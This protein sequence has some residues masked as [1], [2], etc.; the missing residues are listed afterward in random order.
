MCGVV[1]K[2]D[3][4]KMTVEQVW[5]VGKDLGNE[6][7]SPVTGL[8]RYEA[9]KD[10]VTVFYSTAGLS[11]EKSRAS[12]PPPRRRTRISMNTSGARRSLPLKSSSP[13]CS[14]IRPSR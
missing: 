4:K 5:E 12:R 9:D 1:Y 14:A 6:Y 10:S 8:C 2:I 11:F 13:T 7:Y 3:Q